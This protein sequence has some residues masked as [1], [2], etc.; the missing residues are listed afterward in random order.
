LNYFVESGREPQMEKSTN[1]HVEKEL[2]SLISGSGWI[3][4]AVE[5]RVRN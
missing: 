4:S 1:S 2:R 5:E 3:A